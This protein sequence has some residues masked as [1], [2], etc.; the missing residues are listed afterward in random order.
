MESDEKSGLATRLRRAVVETVKTLSPDIQRVPLEQIN[1]PTVAKAICRHKFS[2]NRASK[3]AGPGPFTAF[4]ALIML[5]YKPH[6][7]SN[8][9]ETFF[10][11]RNRTV[12]ALRDLVELGVLEHFEREKPDDHTEKDVYSITKEKKGQLLE[13]AQSAQTE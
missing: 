3:L 11:Q 12:V 4:D 5:G 13:I 8:Y 6:L 10:H 7:S 1:V 2:D 9:R